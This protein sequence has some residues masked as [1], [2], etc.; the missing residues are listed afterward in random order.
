M[1]VSIVEKPSMKVAAIRS[2]CSGKAVRKAWQSVQELLKGHSAVCNDE[3]GHVIIPEWQWQTT[4]TMLWTGVEVS[5]FDDLPDGL[6]TMTI[7]GRK[8]ARITVIGNRERLDATYAYLTEWFRTEGYERDMNEGSYG[9]EANRL[10]P[11]NPFLAPADEIDEFDF[12][13]YAPI[14]ESAKVDSKRFRGVVKIEVQAEKARTIAGMETFVQQTKTIPQPIVGKLWHDFM[15]R[16]EEL[17]DRAD[18]PRSYGILSYKP[19]YGPGQDFAYL[20][21]VEVGR[22]APLPEGFTRRTLPERLVAVVTYQGL[23]REIVQAWRF[24]HEEWSPS[25]GYEALDDYDYEAYDQR[26]YGPDH[27]QSTLEVH[28]PI[29][30]KDRIPGL[31]DKTVFDEKGGFELQDLRDSKVHMA[32]FKGAEFH[33]VDMRNASLEH[34]NFVHSKWR[35]IYFSNVHVDMAQWGGTVFENIKRPDAASSRFEDEAGT[36]GWVN[37]EPVT[38]LNSDLSTAIFDNCELIDV[39][40]RNCRIDGMRINGILVRDLLALYERGGKQS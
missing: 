40:I 22:E 6:E 18:P 34:V 15:Q 32:C 23:G 30:L 13:I 35:H 39:D 3:F 24:F 11:N 33:G 7:P 10:K 26:F 21:G 27:E 17:A 37:V 28:F 36:E 1:Q 16:I 8:Y 20:A 5:S 14:K 31:T 38:F 4:V 29:K 12:D 9:F 19:P 25:S 2:E